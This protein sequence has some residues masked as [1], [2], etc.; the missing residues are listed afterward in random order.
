[1]DLAQLILGDIPAA[2]GPNFERP[3]TPEFEEA[4]LGSVA[5][6][7]AAV[8]DAVERL[9]QKSYEPQLKWRLHDSFYAAIKNGHASIVSYLL[10]QGVDI[11]NLDSAAA[12][13]AKSYEVLQLLLDHGWD[14]NTPMHWDEPPA[15]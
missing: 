10:S 11:I 1:M 13:K 15:L 7:L 2:S 8:K 3:S 14:I 6:D 12:T 5:G 9:K 4:R